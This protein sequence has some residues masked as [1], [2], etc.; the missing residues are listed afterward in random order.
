MRLGELLALKWEDVDFVNNIIKI[1]ATQTISLVNGKLKK[2]ESLPKTKSSYRTIIINK[3]SLSMLQELKKRNDIQ[4]IKTMYVISN[5][6]GDSFNE[7]NFRRDFRKFCERYDIEYKGIHT[8]RHT[9]ASRLFR[10]NVDVLTVS[11][12]LGHSNP[13]IT[14]N[15]YIHILE[16]QKVKAISLMD[17][18]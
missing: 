3:T 10:N 9:F 15:I 17:T 2:A 14:Q 12:L 8:L 11:K 6:N 13:T 1:K 5:L 18:I 4:S 7:N 16:E